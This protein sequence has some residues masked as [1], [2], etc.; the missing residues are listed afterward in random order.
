MKKPYKLILASSFLL[1][2]LMGI[3]LNSTITPWG[4]IWYISALLFVFFSGTYSLMY[5]VTRNRNP[6]LYILVASVGI[7]AVLFFM[8]YMFWDNDPPNP[9]ASQIVFESV[10]M[11]SMYTALIWGVLSGLYFLFNKA[12]QLVMGAFRKQ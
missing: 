10:V 7:T 3:L 8:E 2:L 4:G 12:S 6:Y 5:Y 9:S 1:A 11:G